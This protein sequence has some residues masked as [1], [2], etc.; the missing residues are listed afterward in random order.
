MLPKNSVCRL[1]SE[2]A[3]RQFELPFE[4]APG[5]VDAGSKVILQRG[6]VMHARIE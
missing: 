2:P 6:K 4:F 1:A 5:A 3:R